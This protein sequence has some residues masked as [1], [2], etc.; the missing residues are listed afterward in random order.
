M[1][2]RYEH[3]EF[4]RFVRP[5]LRFLK[6]VQC[7]HSIANTWLVLANGRVHKGQQGCQAYCYNSVLM[8]PK[9]GA[10]LM[11]TLVVRCSWG[12]CRCTLLHTICTQQHA[13]TYSHLMYCAVHTCMN[14]QDYEKLQDMCTPALMTVV[15]W[16]PSGVQVLL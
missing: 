15:R 5:L 16:A 4:G 3:A 11:H 13:A 8:Y 2:C 1:V 9:Y 10:L 12:D 7:D 6:P 14:S